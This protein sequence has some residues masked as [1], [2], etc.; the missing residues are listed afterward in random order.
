[1]CQETIP[2]HSTDQK[3]ASTGTP[4]KQSCAS[5]HRTPNCTSKPPE[6]RTTV[7]QI[8]PLTVCC[9][10]RNLSTTSPDT[11]WVDEQACSHDHIKFATKEKAIRIKHSQER[12][13][14]TL[15]HIRSSLPIPV[16]LYNFCGVASKAIFKQ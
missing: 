12:Q 2:D 14:E 8:Q 7:N 10:Q 4:C 11:M 9:A 1:V 16:D 6:P 3:R 13:E 5:I 15:Q